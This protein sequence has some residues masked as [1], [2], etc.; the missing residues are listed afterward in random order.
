MKFKVG[1]RVRCKD[2][3]SD[4]VVTRHGTMGPHGT[5]VSK[6]KKHAFWNYVRWDGAKG[7]AGVIWC[8]QTLEHVPPEEDPGG[9]AT[10]EGVQRGMKYAAEHKDV[11]SLSLGVPL[12]MLEPDQRVGCMDGDEELDPE[13]NPDLY[14]AYR[15]DERLNIYRRDLPLTFEDL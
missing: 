15:P 13:E 9:Q 3:P 6:G 5:I 11:L 14:T 10:L 8:D 7:K 1:D 2:K 4:P 12:D